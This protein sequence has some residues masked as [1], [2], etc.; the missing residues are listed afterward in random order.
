MKPAARFAL[1]PLA[2]IPVSSLLFTLAIALNGEG[3]EA[4]LLFPFV[5]LYACIFAGLPS[6]AHALW[7]RRQYRAGAAPGGAR[8]LKRGAL[9]GLLSGG[10]VGAF[11]FSL[12]AFPALVWFPLLG[13]ATGLLSGLLQRCFRRPESATC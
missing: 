6:V 9:S 7:M 13:A 12:G 8:A 5:V 11:F 10:V 3:L 4:L 1:D 2:P